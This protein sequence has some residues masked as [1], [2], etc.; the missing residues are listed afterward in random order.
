MNFIK[1]TDLDE[2]PVYIN[3]SMILS[4]ESGPS[5]GSKIKMVMDDRILK[6]KQSPDELIKKVKTGTYI[7]LINKNNENV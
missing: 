7:N 1:L 3:A 5:N 2:Q 4:I 6:V